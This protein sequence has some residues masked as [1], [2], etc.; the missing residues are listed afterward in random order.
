MLLV[1]EMCLLQWYYISIPHLC[2]RSSD[3]CRG[4]KIYTPKLGQIR[5]KLNL[6][7]G[8]IAHEV[9]LS[10]NPSSTR[11]GIGY[12][13]N[14]LTCRKDGGFGVKGYGCCSLV[15]SQ[16]I[17]DLCQPTLG[18][19]LTVRHDVLAAGGGVKE[20]EQYQGQDTVVILGW[21]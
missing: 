6:A 11:W 2:R 10:P 1:P 3:T 4:E 13:R 19:R 5:A 9:M 7:K 16:D 17:L 18:K 21:G 15:E 12:L 8:I 14:I 20:V